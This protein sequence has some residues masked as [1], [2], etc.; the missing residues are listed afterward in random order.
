MYVITRCC[1]STEQTRRLTKNSPKPK[2]S[3]HL[4]LALSDMLPF[5]LILTH[6][7]LLAVAGTLLLDWMS[8]QGSYTFWGRGLASAILGRPWLSCTE[9]RA[10]VATWLLMGMF[11][12]ATES[13]SKLRN[14][15][16]PVRE[17]VRLIYLLARERKHTKCVV[18]KNIKGETT[19]KDLQKQIL[20][21]ECV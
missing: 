10:W 18:W 14:F 21:L 1:I 19:E 4:L 5:R 8:V 9:A 12:A 13:P 17:S 7:S 20:F 2:T 15:W 11:L 3:K 6:I 16:W